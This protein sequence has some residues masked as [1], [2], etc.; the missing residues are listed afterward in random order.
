[1]LITRVKGLEVSIQ[2]IIAFRQLGF[3]RLFAAVK[4]QSRAFADMVILS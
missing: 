3:H 1:M 4:E 2:R